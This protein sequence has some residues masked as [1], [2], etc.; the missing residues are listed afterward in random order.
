MPNL[1]DD[2]TELIAYL[3]T[4]ISLAAY[5]LGAVV[6]ARHSRMS[7]WMFLVV[8][9]LT[10]EALSGGFFRVVLWAAEQNRIPSEMGASLA[11]LAR[12]AASSCDIL[13]VVGLTLV[14]RELRQ[15]MEFISHTEEA[16]RERD[17]MKRQE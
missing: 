3:L 6:A 8:A 14:F 2:P 5:L 10:G 12:I 11:S 13:L 17:G 16:T 4:W 15:R 1:P 7:S 9:A